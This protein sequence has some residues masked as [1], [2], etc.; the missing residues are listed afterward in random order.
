MYN[1]PTSNSTSVLGASFT[2]APLAL[3]G[4]RPGVYCLMACFMLIAGLLLTRSGRFNPRVFT[5]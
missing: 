2:A 5:P 3:T 4:S 1:V